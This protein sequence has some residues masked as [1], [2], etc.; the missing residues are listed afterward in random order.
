MLPLGP[1][2]TLAQI[3]QLT[4]AAFDINMPLP[5]GADTVSALL[6][7]V[8]LRAGDAPWWQS[9]WLFRQL[10]RLDAMGLLPRPGGH[11]NPEWLAALEA[12]TCA[13][14]QGWR[15][16]Q[17]A[18]A[19]RRPAPNLWMLHLTR[20]LL[21]ASPGPSPQAALE[22]LPGDLVTAA[23][24][25]FAARKPRPSATARSVAEFLSARGLGPEVEHPLLGGLTTIDIALPDHRIAIEARRPRGEGRQPPLGHG[26]RMLLC[27]LGL[28][29][30]PAGRQRLSS[31]GTQ[32]PAQRADGA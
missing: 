16:H 1:S 3:E 23:E 9:A 18:P 2:T 14:A 10:V 28:T 13:V 29:P 26:E 27:A 15:Q 6:A 22:Q 19:E 17:D 4:T 31:P 12:L 25:A 32:R 11:N 7:L 8:P 24:A 20:L 21:A 30:W 5:G